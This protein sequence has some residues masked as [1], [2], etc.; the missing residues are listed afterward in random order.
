MEKAY[1]ATEI[2]NIIEEAKTIQNLEN[3]KTKYKNFKDSYPGIFEMITSKN[4]NY[5]L[6]N[7]LIQ[8]KKLMEKGILTETKASEA[9][10]TILVDRF[11]KPNLK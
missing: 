5:E 6:L 1:S 10:G 3:F 9:V 7:H 4:C 8:H 2:E 11:V